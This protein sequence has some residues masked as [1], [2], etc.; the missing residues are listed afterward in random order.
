MIKMKLHDAFVALSC[1][2][3]AV[4]VSTQHVAGKAAVPALGFDDFLVGRPSLG[5]FDQIAQIR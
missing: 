2:G 3:D 5:K 4:G 1:S